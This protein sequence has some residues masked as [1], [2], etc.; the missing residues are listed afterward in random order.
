MANHCPRSNAGE[1][2]SSSLGTPKQAIAGTGF[3]FFS[4]QGTHK[5]RDRVQKKEGT[6]DQGTSLIV[7]ERSRNLQ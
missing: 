2:L 6:L 5:K 4:V 7:Q 1:G 3:F